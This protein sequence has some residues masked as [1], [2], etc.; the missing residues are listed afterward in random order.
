MPIWFELVAL[1][2][3]AYVIGLGIG[4][5]LWGRSESLSPDADETEQT[6]AE[7]PVP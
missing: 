3:A 2:L 6:S 5:M 7:G 4:W 1:S